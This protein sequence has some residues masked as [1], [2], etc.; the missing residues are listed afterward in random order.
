MCIYIYI[1]EGCPRGPS[2]YKK[3]YPDIYSA[4]ATSIIAIRQRAV[5]RR[6]SMFATPSGHSYHY[7][8]SGILKLTET[9][10]TADGMRTERARGKLQHTKRAQ[11]GIQELFGK[12]CHT[13]HAFPIVCPPETSSL[14][15]AWMEPAQYLQHALPKLLN[16]ATYHMYTSL[17]ELPTICKSKVGV[18]V[19]TISAMP[20]AFSKHL[21]KYA[22]GPVFS[23]TTPTVPH[24]T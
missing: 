19:G 11:T 1:Y 22:W 21:K 5:H 24:P 2:C 10:A 20:Y 18:H 12:L 23:H 8:E 15:L 6:Q 9:N 7:V 13:P 4:T 14:W 16:P 17:L 3:V